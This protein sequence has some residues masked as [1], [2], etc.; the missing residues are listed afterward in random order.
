MSRLRL[1]IVFAAALTCLVFA[2]T[3]NAAGRLTET[4]QCDGQ[5]LTILTQPSSGDNWGAVQ[6]VGD[7]T[8][9]PLAFE[10]TLYDVTKDMVVF[11]DSV[12]KGSGSAP[13]GLEGSVTTCTLTETAL[14]SEFLEP[15]EEPP[16]GTDLTDVV[17]FTLTATVIL[18]P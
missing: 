13:A 15:G 16:P 5:T 3:A 14:L 8:L 7:G 12:A 4:V 17:T 18:R 10:F 6:V 9:I 11:T 2:T 1:V